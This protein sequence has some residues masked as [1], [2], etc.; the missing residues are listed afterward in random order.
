MIARSMGSL[1]S[2]FLNPGTPLEY[3]ENALDVMQLNCNK[4]FAKV[5]DG[6]FISKLVKFWFD[7]ITI[8]WIHSWSETGTQKKLIQVEWSIKWSTTEYKLRHSISL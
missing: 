4:A 1:I 5:A 8:Q 7:D 2:F 6:I 3:C